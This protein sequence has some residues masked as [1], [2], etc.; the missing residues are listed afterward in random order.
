MQITQTQPTTFRAKVS[1]EVRS[2]IA[3]ELLNAPSLRKNRN[4]VRQQYKNIES[5][6]NKNSE[7]VLCENQTSQKQLGVK[8]FFTPQ[9]YIIK[10]IENLRNCSVIGK[11]LRLKEFD[12]INT[13][14][15]IEKSL[16]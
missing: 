3:K 7:I 11:F 6:G 1:D 8:Y 5:W 13:E 10:R 12:I 16:K 14:I 4:A 15:N 9:R 2:V